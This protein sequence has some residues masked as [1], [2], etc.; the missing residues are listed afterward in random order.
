MIR[1]FHHEPGCSDRMDDAFDRGHR[2][3]PKIHPLHDG[4]IHPLHPVELSL[5]SSPGVEEPR[6]F[7]NNDGALDSDDRRSAL[8]EDRMAS[9]ECLGEAGCLAPG[10]RATSRA[11]V[12]E[13]EGT[14]TAQL[15]R[16]SRAFW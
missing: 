13:D 14:R 1:F 3:R 10:H 15:K 11:S 2:A 6:L 4:G 5:G 12:S 16:R 9:H 8:P 7:E